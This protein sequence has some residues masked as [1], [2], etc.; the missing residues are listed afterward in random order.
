MG[1]TR[2]LRGGATPSQL[3]K[4]SFTLSRPKRKINMGALRGKFGPLREIN[5]YGNSNDEELLKLN[6]QIRRE[7]GMRKKNAELAGL[8]N[9]ELAGLFGSRQEEEEELDR[10][11][12][13][14]D[15]KMR[16]EEARKRKEEMRK[17]N[18]ELAGLFGSLQVK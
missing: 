6:T 15:R 7:E 14:M 17:K 5:S 11:L 2:R 10:N 9:A 8:K 16:K 13:E 1:Q 3:K 18:A 12:E 4:K